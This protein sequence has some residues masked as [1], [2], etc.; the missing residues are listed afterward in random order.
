MTYTVPTKQ[1]PPKQRINQKLEKK[2]M[3]QYYK[4]FNPQPKILTQVEFKKKNTLKLI[5]H[6]IH[7]RIWKEENHCLFIFHDTAL[8]PSSNSTNQK[9]AQHRSIFFDHFISR[10]LTYFKH[11]WNYY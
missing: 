8:Q 3:P 4:N 6:F 5:K 9:L 11:I 10:H 7:F 2:I 1:K